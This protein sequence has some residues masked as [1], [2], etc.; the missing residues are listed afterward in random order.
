[1]RD[2]DAP[3]YD[4]DAQREEGLPPGAGEFRRRL[5]ACHGFVVASPEYNASMPGALKNAI[6]RIT[7]A[8]KRAWAARQAADL[9][10]GSAPAGRCSWTATPEGQQSS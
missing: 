7:D 2:F 4:Q 8:V 6:D 10:P 5:E 9:A 3:S 1:M